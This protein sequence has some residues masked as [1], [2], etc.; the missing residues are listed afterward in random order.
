LCV[1]L[2]RASAVC[3]ALPHLQI[4]KELTNDLFTLREHFLAVDLAYTLADASALMTTTHADK[5]ILQITVG[6]SDFLEPRDPAFDKMLG[7]AKATR[8]GH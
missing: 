4:D 8:K 6:T 1:E 7:D 3:S 2:A 5:Q